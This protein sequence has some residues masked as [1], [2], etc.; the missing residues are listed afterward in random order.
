MIAAGEAGY[1]AGRTGQ[2][3][4]TADFISHWAASERGWAPALVDT[5][6]YQWLLEHIEWSGMKLKGEQARS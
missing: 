4:I 2:A 3:E 1:I 6:S 5:I